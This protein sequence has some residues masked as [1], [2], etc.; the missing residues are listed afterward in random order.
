MNPAPSEHRLP[1]CAIRRLSPARLALPNPAAFHLT[2]PKTAQLPFG[3]SMR[4]KNARCA[5]RT[6]HDFIHKLKSASIIH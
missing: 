6:V 5:E 1:P 4:R 3:G 2:V